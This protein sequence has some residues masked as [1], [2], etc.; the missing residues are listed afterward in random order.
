M[1]CFSS[2]GANVRNASF[3][4]TPHAVTFDQGVNSFRFPGVKPDM[5]RRLTSSLSM[6]RR[7]PVIQK[8]DFDFPPEG[9][10]SVQR[11]RLSMKL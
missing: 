9:L 2:S 10:R 4:E 6:K 7:S 1:R 8:A 11:E 5:E 3:S